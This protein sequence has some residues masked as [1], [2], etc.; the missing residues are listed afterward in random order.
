MPNNLQLHEVTC[1][2]GNQ[3]LFQPVSFRLSSGEV[4]QISGVNGSGKTSLLR[5]VAGL[6]LIQGGEIF[7]NGKS[8]HEI[9]S[10]YMSQLS[11][12]GHKLGLKEDLTVAENIE[13]MGKKTGV[14]ALRGLRSEL[15]LWPHLAS[16][17]AVEKA[18]PASL[19]TQ[20]QSSQVRDLS[21]GQK[22]RVVLAKLIL[23]PRELWILDEPFTGLDREGIEILVNLIEQHRLR[24][25]LI[26]LTSHQ[27]VPLKTITK[28]MILQ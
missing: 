13:A 24:G 26:I 11:Y 7:W 16:L 27:D 22:R 6:G 2:R 3:T 28:K 18:H 20:L 10:L 1:E 5:R 25:G 17:G 14:A 8:I 9:Q 4:L 15:R 12:V 21:F 23:F 19:G